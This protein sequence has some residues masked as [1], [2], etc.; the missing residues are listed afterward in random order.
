MNNDT[1]GYL[2]QI[3]ASRLTYI[4]YAPDEKKA[5]ELVQDREGKKL[6]TF[7]IEEISI[8]NWH[9]IETVVTTEDG[10][11]NV[12][13][14]RYIFHLIDRNNFHIINTWKKESV[15]NIT[16]EEGERGKSLSIVADYR[17]LV[18]SC[19]KEFKEQV[20]MY[21]RSKPDRLFSEIK[22]SLD[23]KYG[24]YFLKDINLLERFDKDVVKDMYTDLSDEDK[25]I[26][27][28]CILKSLES[29]LDGE[30]DKDLIVNTCKHNINLSVSFNSCDDKDIQTLEF[31]F[32]YP[33]LPDRNVKAFYHTVK[34][35]LQL[36]KVILI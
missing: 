18:A 15:L 11:E 36:S 33:Y 1:L 6:E 23:Q 34:N 22:V 2:Y 7:T 29:D 14:Y 3:T 9:N 21:D 12:N 32:N 35:K 26:L 17:E 4:V 5:I 16:C 13:L 10:E 27:N 25:A 31:G 19:L 30:A 8:R 24:S 28:F 20:P